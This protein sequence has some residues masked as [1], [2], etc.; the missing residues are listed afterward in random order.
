MLNIY[1]RVDPEEVRRHQSEAAKRRHAMTA[2]QRA[3]RNA[4]IVRL[5]NSKD[6]FW[7][8]SLLGE[9]FGLAHSQIAHI[10]KSAAN[11]TI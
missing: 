11:P 3:A 6:E 10:L 2:N 5:Y 8:L 4:E 7:S 9:K 1:V